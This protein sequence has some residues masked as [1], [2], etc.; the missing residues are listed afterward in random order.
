[1]SHGYDAQTVIQHTHDRLGFILIAAGVSAVG[2]YMQYL[3]AMRR[4]ARDKTFC[5]PLATNLWNF[6][7]DTT[8][9][10]SYR[11]WFHSEDHDFWLLK[12]FWVG[13]IVFS[14][15]EVVVICQILRWGREDL[16]GGGSLV[17]A[18]LI[19]AVLQAMVFGIFWW[20][21]EITADPLEYYG[22]TTTVIMAS[23]FNIPMMK[24]RGSRR[25]MSEFILWGYLILSAGFWPWMM[26]SDNSFCRP[27]YWLIAIG[28][29]GVCIESIR[30]YRGLPEYR[31]PGLGQD[32][33]RARQ[34]E[35]APE[36]AVRGRPHA[37]RAARRHVAAQAHR[38]AGVRQ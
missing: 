20:F 30:V 2:G 17:R 32:D 14:I 19:Y 11:S 10:A 12:L 8:F 5:I 16:F 24:S 33:P 18:L 38:V 26:L 31:P 15:F 3:G 7:H 6:A 35:A 4:G 29:L 27:V 25:G 22:L 9:V 21:Q 34:A 23:A 36:A 28:N 37:F 13:L 1:V